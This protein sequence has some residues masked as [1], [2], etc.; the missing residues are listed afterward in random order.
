MKKSPFRMLLSG[1]YGLPRT[2]WLF[3]VIGFTIIGCLLY[4]SLAWDLWLT[5]WALILFD[6][7]YR[8]CVWIGIWCAARQYKGST[9][10]V[11]LARVSVVLVVLANIFSLGL[12]VSPSFQEYV[13]PTS[14]TLTFAPHAYTLL[15][16]QNVV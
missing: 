16:D 6:T 13:L 2:F 4:L 8:V 12:L 3:G 11:F 5:K 9:L 14:T 7:F 15:F 1:G 10:W